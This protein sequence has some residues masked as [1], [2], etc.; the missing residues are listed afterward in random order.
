MR[1]TIAGASVLAAA[2]GLAMLP[3]AA[4]ASAED[5]RREVGVAQCDP[6]P[7]QTCTPIPSVTFDGGGRTIIHFTSATHHCSTIFV[8]VKLD[9]EDMG[10][11]AVAPG[12]RINVVRDGLPLGAHTVTVQAHGVEGG[13]NKGQLD[14]WGGTVQINTQSTPPTAPKPLQGPA[15]S[16]VPAPPGGLTAHIRDRSGKDAQCTYTSDW[17][18]R[19]FFLRANSTYDLVIFPAVP[20]FRNWNVTIKCD[21]GTST[22]TQTFF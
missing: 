1:K 14:S 10:G 21:N 17:Y 11:G 4:P 13:C 19:S 2:T 20:K 5:I 3:L 7:D 8:T 12:H 22:E 6:P 15:V 9:G 16:W 18:T